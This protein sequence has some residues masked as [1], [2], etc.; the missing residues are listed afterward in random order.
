MSCHFRLNHS[1]AAVLLGCACL[2]G[3]QKGPSNTKAFAPETRDAVATTFYPTAW[4]AEQILGDLV[5]VE[6][7]L[8][9]GED[10]SSWQPRSAAIESYQS[11]KLIVTNGAGFEKWV[12]TVTL[13]GSRV[14]DT[15]GGLSEPF[16]QYENAVVHQHGPGGE[17]SHEGTD[18]H[19]WLD[20]IT[21]KHQAQQIADA[22]SRAWP[23]HVDAISANLKSLQQRL[24]SLDKRFS[25]ITPK[26]DGVR[27]LCSHPAYNYIARRYGW[28]IQ[29]FDLDPDQ[30]IADEQLAAWSKDQSQQKTVMLWESEPIAT[31]Q[32]QLIDAGVTEVVF[33]PCEARPTMGDFLS[34][35]NQNLDRLAAAVK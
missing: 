6:C 20:P 2:A 21:A 13:P 19:T 7:P 23:Q 17:H 11:A 32:S 34:V 26:L 31:A 12:G 14:V 25:E 9:Q 28:K 35:M 15:T 4:M 16:I 30:P 5:P 1:V 18:G 29:N 10:P 27:L 33:S 8:P 22:A 24:D 3:C